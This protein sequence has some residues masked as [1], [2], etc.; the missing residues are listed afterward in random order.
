MGA[1]DAGRRIDE[2][3]AEML[4]I[5]RRAAVRLLDEVRRNGRRVRKGDRVAAGE[6]ILL[7]RDPP[8]AE[9]AAGWGS[10]APGGEGG[11]PIVVRSTPDVLVVDKP[12]G[13]PS[14]ALAGRRGPSLAAWAARHDPACEGV[15]GAGENGL[16]HR[17][18]GATSGLLLVARNEDA[19]ADLRDQ[20]SRRE[21]EKTY[22][23][24]VQGSPGDAVD[25]D[26]PVGRHPRS[27]RRMVAVVGARDP[28]RY[29]ARPAHTRIE[30][31]ARLDGFA[32]VRAVTSSGARHQ[33][34]VHLAHAGHPLAGDSLY[35]GDPLPGLDGFL[36]HA[37]ALRWREPGTRREATDESPRPARWTEI[38]DRLG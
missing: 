17:L 6:E 2:V 4:G 22:L 25:V 15:G 30:T 32:V 37:C 38:L 12:A 36:L 3:V 5:G 9:P 35:G 23:A 1:I 21:I 10:P 16:A 24:L 19:W 29:A 14:V 13:L 18:D 8:G 11:S 26:A 31:L 27:R 34:R 33:V 20:F 7:P 28:G